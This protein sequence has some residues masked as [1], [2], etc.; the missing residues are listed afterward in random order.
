MAMSESIERQGVRNGTAQLSSLAPKRRAA[1]R[2]MGRRF[3]CMSV[4]LCV[5]LVLIKSGVGKEGEA[6]LSNNS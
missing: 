1:A 4:G 6:L 3:F 2:S 5:D